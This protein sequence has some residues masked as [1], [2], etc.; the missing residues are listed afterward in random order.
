MIAKELLPLIKA[1]GKGDR[2]SE[3]LV[4]WVKRWDKTRGNRP[5]SVT[6]LHWSNIDGS[7]VEYLP[8]T[9]Q[10]NHI[11]I[12]DGDN[13]EWFYGCKLSQIIG[14]G[15][16]SSDVFAYP[17]KMTKTPLPDWFQGYIKGGKCF[18]DP[19]H[20]LYYDK[21][22]WQVSEDGNTRNCLWCGEVAQQKIIK[23]RTVYDISWGAE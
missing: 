17:P 9:T 7:H 21:E 14:G 4:K 6:F 16:G 11:L 3:N 18:I 19:E 10:P 23:E 1:K 5:L 8:G 13:E 2:F 22:R 20:R 15:R 12:G